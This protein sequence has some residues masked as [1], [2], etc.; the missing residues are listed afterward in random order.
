MACDDLTVTLQ[1]ISRQGEKHVVPLSGSSE[2]LSFSFDDVLPGKYKGKGG[3][4][5]GGVGG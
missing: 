1:P 5:V 3:L 4:G 2:T